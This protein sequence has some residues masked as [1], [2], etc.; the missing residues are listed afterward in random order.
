MTG[1]LPESWARFEL[2]DIFTAERGAS[3]DPRRHPDTEFELFSV[4][5]HPT[6]APEV[7]TGGEVGSSKQQVQPGTV[8]LCRINPRI[9]RVWVIPAAED[10]PQ[11]AST[12]WIALPP[13]PGIHPPFLAYSLQRGQVRDYL[14]A[15]VS[16][17]GGSLMRARKSDVTELL[18]P[19]APFPEQ[20]R[21][22][23]KL[24]EL[25]SELDAGVAALE[26]AQA[27]LERYRASVLKAAVQGR[28]TERWRQENPPTE[29]GAELL[30]RILAERRRRWEEEQLAEFEAK[31]KKPPTDWKEKYK[32]PMAPDSD[33]LPELPEGWCW[34]TVDQLARVVRGASPRP[35]GDPRYFGGSHIPWITVGEL[36]GVQ[37]LYLRRV[38]GFLTERGRRHSRVIPADTL[39]LTNSGA[40]LGV[41]RITLIEGC[42][43]DGSVALLEVP[44][45]LKL[46]LCLYLS[47]LTKSLRVNQQGAAQPNLNTDIVKAIRVPV[48]PAAEQAAIGRLVE[49]ALSQASQIA[50]STAATVARTAVLRQ[51]I[52]AYAFQGRLV[53]QAPNDEPAS[54]LLERIRAEREAEA[55]RPK[56]KTKRPRKKAPSA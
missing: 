38:S 13:R 31:G 12:E 21:I 9:N 3:L 2:G 51:S 44:Y 37:D 20:Q 18:L 54:V 5:A 26:R 53:P 17:V 15:H 27:K 6:G 10:R 40:T 16:G 55:E 49:A 33:G 36:T 41:P 8:L 14:A 47:T 56:P 30:E 1:E 32:Q 50:A 29:T 45:P 34:A 25:F 28:L 22:V 4:P 19:L 52:L 35:A 39:L 24:D 11:I 43:N 7:V 42:I 23:T 46:Y 48:P